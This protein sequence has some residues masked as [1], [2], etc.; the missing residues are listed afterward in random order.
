MENLDCQGINPGGKG[1]IS[2]G[3]LLPEQHEV[4]K[5]IRKGW[6]INPKTRIVKNKKK[7]YNRTLVKIET[8]KL[9]RK[10]DF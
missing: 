7:K 3:K 9:L 10:E 8:K 6:S 4:Y 2:L 5:K 1:K